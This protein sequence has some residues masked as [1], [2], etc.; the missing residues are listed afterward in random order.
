MEKIIQTQLED[1]LQ[2]SYIDYAMSVI[3]GRAIP[4]ARDGL[5][6]AQRRILY[7]MYNI[8]NFHN[9]PTKK[10][11]RVVGEVIG[12]YHPHGDIA[13][14]D[15]LVRLAQDFAMNHVLVEG[16]GNFGSIDGD[17]P[18]AM[19]YTEVRLTSFAEEML[20]D[21]D[22]DTVEFVPNFDN[23]EKEP[24]TLPSKIP[25]LLVNGASGIA[26]GVATSIPPHNLIE[27]CNA[28]IYTIE[29]EDATVEDLLKIIKGPDFPTGG[30]ALMS[31]NAYNGYRYGRGQVRVRAK[32]KIDEK[33][34]EIIISEI[35]YNVNKS[36]LIKNIVELVKEKKITGISNLRDESGKEGVHIVIELKNG[37]KGDGVLNALYRHTQL[38]VTFPIINLAVVGKSLKNF[39]LLQL[40]QTFINYRREVIKRR[41]TF[42]LNKASERVHILDG[43]IIAISNINEVVKLIRE[44]TSASDARAK[45]MASFSLSEK[46]ANAIL[47]M[48][49]SRLTHLEY[50]SISGERSSLLEKIKYYNEVLSNPKEVDKI[51]IDETSEIKQKYGR[52]RR[53]EIIEVEEDEMELK[54]EDLIS[55]ERTTVIYTHAGYIKR[56]GLDYYKEQ[57]RGGKGIIAINLKEGD[58]VK[59][60]MTCN[61]KDYLLCISDKGR[62]YWLRAYRIP[63]GNR[64]SEGKSIV[65]LLNLK[66]ERIIVLFPLRDLENSNIVLLTKKGLVKKMSARLFSRPRSTGIAAI[67]LRENDSVVYAISYINEK[68]LFIMSKLGKAIKFEERELRHVGRGAMG[69]RGIKLADG[70]EAKNIIAAG[71]I[72]YILT[73]TENG[74]GKLTE[75]SRYRVQRRGGVGIINIKVTEKTGS[76]AKSIFLS[77]EA[78]VV[79]INSKGIAISFDAASIRITGRNA[80]GVRL[81]KLDEGAKVI[82]AQVFT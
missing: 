79:L 62:A 72:G 49:L 45:L 25:N 27:V 52:G 16:Q 69:V 18:A 39:N 8:N 35:P 75:V 76:V 81:M 9:Q 43:L 29:H 67:T 54:E 7:A 78:N 4:D 23:T 44:S 61:T 41:T 53:T 73:V 37:E 12:K 6:P 14:Y 19:R 46:Q 71:D 17:P 55:N 11:A 66:E 63:E 51:I 22:K 2:S 36:E 58:Y 33:K 24:V 77:G 60:I 31:N 47:E 40:I 10:S 20:A 1:E 56:M 82:D 13:V 70:D 28:I 57:A 42:E 48:K 50:D 64:Y 38:E 15:A 74:Y 32:A 59:Q 3:I 5:K 30:I 80:S 65:N 26:V 21:L 34:N 68:Y